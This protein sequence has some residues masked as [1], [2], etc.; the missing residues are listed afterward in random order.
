MGQKH[1]GFA[2]LICGVLLLAACKPETN[3]DSPPEIVYGEDACD[4]C[5]MIISEP[6]HAASYLTTTGAAHLFDDIGG[7]LLYHAEHNE[8]VHSFWVHD[9]ESEEWL[10]A[11]NAF[12]VI[13]SAVYTPMGH[14]IFAF[15]NEGQAAEFAEQNQKGTVLGFS[16]LLALAKDGNLRSDHQQEMHQTP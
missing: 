8:E 3:L 5:N 10:R 14:G 13:N 4:Y 16:E 7:M 6:R 1:L 11:E 12:Y 15:E 2:A 9:Y